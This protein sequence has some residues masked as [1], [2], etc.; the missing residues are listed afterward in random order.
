MLFLLKVIFLFLPLAAVSAISK[1]DISES[2]IFMRHAYAPGNGDPIFFTLNDCKTQRNLNHEGRQQS[3][4]I[5]EHM[6]SKDIVFS[7]I[8]SSEWCRCLETA[9]L[10]K[11][12]QVKPFFGLNSF[13]ENHFDKREIMEA[14][15]NKISNINVKELPILMITHY[16]NI[17]E[18][19]GL[20]VRSG[21]LVKYNVI[22][23]EST[24]FL[25][26]N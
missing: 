16:V 17:L 1:S 2:V 13:Y 22:T 20:P 25:L 11:M 12:G 23:E 7:K 3:I 8:Y 21:D 10:L 19:T 4:S 26:N 6:R 5:G 9:D 18:I 24:P 15:K 14:L